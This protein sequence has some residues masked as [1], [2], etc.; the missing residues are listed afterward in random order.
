[1]QAALVEELCGAGA[2]VDGLDDDGTPPWT[3]TTFG[4]TDAAEALVRCG[5]RVDKIVFAAALGDLAAVESYFGAGSRLKSDNSGIPSRVGCTGPTIDRDRI[6]D[7][8]LIQAAAHNRRKVVEFLLAKDPDLEF[9]GPSSTPP[10]AASPATRGMRRSSRCSTLPAGE[11]ACSL[12]Q[13]SG[14]GAAPRE[15]LTFWL[16]GPGTALATVSR[17]LPKRARTWLM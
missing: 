11:P 16:Q 6:V 1:V 12:E 10:P 3:A 4:H 8:A 15:L 2:R 17:R 14:A 7:N 13:L 9:R 5:A